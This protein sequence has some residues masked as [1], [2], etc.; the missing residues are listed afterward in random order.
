M[1]SRTR[2]SVPISKKQ[3]VQLLKTGVQFFIFIKCKLLV[4]SVNVFMFDEL[5]IYQKIK[6]LIFSHLYF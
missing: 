1:H 3:G 2:T 6:L 5:K 4:I